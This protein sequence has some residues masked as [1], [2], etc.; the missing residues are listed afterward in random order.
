MLGCPDEASD[1]YCP[2]RDPVN[3]GTVM[4][5]NSSYVPARLMRR[6][7]DNLGGTDVGI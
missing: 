7:A 2:N 1:T 6:F 4:D 3:T 5:N